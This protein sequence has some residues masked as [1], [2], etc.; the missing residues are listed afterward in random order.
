MV[1]EVGRR[2]RNRLERHRAFLTTAKA[3]VAAE[4]LDALTM[5]RLAA[6]LDCAVGTAYTYFPS[7]SALVAEVQREAIDRLTESYARFATTFDAEVAAEGSTGA[8]IALGRIVG[9]G[10]FCVAILDTFPEEARLLQ[11]LMADS[12][13][14]L[15]EDGDVH[16]VI[17]AAF[18]FV[19]HAQAAF[20]AA[21]E[22]GALRAGDA[23]DRTVVLLATINGVLAVDNLAR[24]DPDL[25]DG[26]RLALDTLPV[27][28]LGWGA[29]PD[30]LTR[31][32]R[33]VDALA[34]RGPLAPVPA[35]LRDPHLRDPDLRD[36]ES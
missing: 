22:A 34:R 5:Q 1:Q 30:A 28:L 6:E 2:Q 20:E 8:D 11:M 26:R 10:R 29:D 9:F 33:P 7:K 4:G 23:I 16:R 18:R 27:L 21:V 17:P 13:R 19:G 32:G 31:A 25:F 12:R 24:V 35:D 3:L 15:I 14:T 36:K